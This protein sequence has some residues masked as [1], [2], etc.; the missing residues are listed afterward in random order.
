MIFDA[1]HSSGDVPPLTVV[2]STFKLDT[3]SNSYRNAICP[4]SHFVDGCEEPVGAALD[5]DHGSFYDGF[6][7]VNPTALP[8]S[9]QKDRSQLV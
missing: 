4:L 1:V 2:T 5:F 3:T 6:T 8:L 7:T 9:Q